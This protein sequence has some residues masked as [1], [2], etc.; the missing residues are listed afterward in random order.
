MIC[1]I[2][3]MASLTQGSEVLR[4]AIFWLVVEMGYRKHYI[5]L[6]LRCR[7]V[8][9]RMVFR[10]AELAA[11]VSPFKYLRPYLLPVLR[12]SVFVLWSYRHVL[13][14]FSQKIRYHY[15]LLLRPYHQ[16][17]HPVLGIGNG[18]IVLVCHSSHQV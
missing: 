7:A 3:V 9:P 8:N 10:S 6:V 17:L 1:I 16:R 13:I 14:L 5:Y 4:A 18:G 12:V 15:Q 2:S 11:V